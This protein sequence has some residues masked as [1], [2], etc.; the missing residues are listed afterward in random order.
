MNGLRDDDD[1]ESAYASRASF[2][3]EYSAQEPRRE[4]VQLLFKEHGRTGSKGSNSSGVSS[5]KASQGNLRPET[6]V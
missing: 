1:A 4:G 6:K 3:S 5:L 2:T